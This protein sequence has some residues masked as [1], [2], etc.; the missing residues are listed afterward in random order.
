MKKT[1]ERADHTNRAF[2]RVFKKVFISL[3]MMSEKT[4]ISIDTI[5]GWCKRNMVPVAEWPNLMEEFYSVGVDVDANMLNA[6]TF[7]HMGK[8]NE[9]GRLC[10]TKIH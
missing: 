1:R 10:R 7:I 2:A 3:K 8:F 4:G 5:S 9:V 6:I